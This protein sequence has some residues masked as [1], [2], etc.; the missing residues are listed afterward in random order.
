MARAYSALLQLTWLECFW[1]LAI[2]L[3]RSL[4]VDRC[5]DPTEAPP[6]PPA[7][8]ATH[9]THLDIS[10]GLIKPSEACKLLAQLQ[11]HKLQHLLLRVRTFSAKNDQF[12]DLAVSIR[13][14]MAPGGKLSLEATYERFKLE[15]PVTHITVHR[16][17]EC[18]EHPKSLLACCQ[19]S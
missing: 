2:G 7:S 1:V 8:T 10:G 12:I 6:E 5:E 16:R 9:L 14:V 11:P 18:T 19:T 15:Q 4:D 17:R 3:C 13:R